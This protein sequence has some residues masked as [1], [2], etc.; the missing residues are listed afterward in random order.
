MLSSIGLNLLSTGRLSEGLI[1]MR[2]IIKPSSELQNSYNDI[3]EI[4][5]TM[6]TPVFLTK[7][8]V[9]DTVLMDVGTYNKREEDLSVAERLL[10]AERARLQG[11]KGY[12][13][14]EFERNMREAIE[15]GVTH[16]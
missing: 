15:R 12:Q 16:G 2:A 8:G 7:N 14:A 6:Q 3:A 11:V 10:S 13:I 4:C 5:R 1:C 9:G